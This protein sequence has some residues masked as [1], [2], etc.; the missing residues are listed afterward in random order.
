MDAMDAMDAMDGVLRSV[1]VML[2]EGAP[3]CRC[4]GSAPFW[5]YALLT[6]SH[7]TIVRS[8]RC[9]RDTCSGAV[10]TALVGSSRVTKGQ[11][12]RLVARLSHQPIEVR[13]NV[14]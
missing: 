11:F 1:Q 9:V 2:D 13:Q 7:C 5:P 6:C 3:L 10:A 8:V 14:K 12:G 4:M